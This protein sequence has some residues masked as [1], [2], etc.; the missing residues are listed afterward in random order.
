VNRKFNRT[1][2]NLLGKPLVDPVAQG[3][4]A[5]TPMSV[6]GREN[7]DGTE[8]P[9]AWFAYHRATRECVEFTSYEEA[10][11]FCFHPDNRR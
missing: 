10:A 9:T 1:I 6:P 3:K 8:T 11:A 7:S 4:T 2:N 5:W